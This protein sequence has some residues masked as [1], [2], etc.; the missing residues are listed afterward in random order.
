MRINRAGPMFTFAFG[1][2]FIQAIHGNHR[3]HAA[4]PF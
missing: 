3:S 4:S 1:D 2:Y